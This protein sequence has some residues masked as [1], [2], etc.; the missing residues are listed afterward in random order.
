MNTYKKQL[1]LLKEGDKF[2]YEDEICTIFAHEGDMT[3]VFKNNKFW[4]WPKWSGIKP[5]IVDFIN[6]GNQNNT[7]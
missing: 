2:V 1:F 6:Y 4:A 7:K 5:T 3:E